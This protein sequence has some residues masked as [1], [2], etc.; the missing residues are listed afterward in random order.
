MALTRLA[1]LLVLRSAASSLSAAQLPR[2]FGRKEGSVAVLRDD[3]AAARDDAAA[4]PVSQPVPLAL[5]Q[6]HLYAFQAGGYKHNRIGAASPVLPPGCAAARNEG[7]VLHMRYSNGMC[8]QMIM[9][10]NVRVLAEQIGWG[11]T[12]DAAAPSADRAQVDWARR[13]PAAPQRIDVPGGGGGRARCAAGAGNTSSSGRGGAARVGLLWDEP[14][15]LPPPRS[16]GARGDGDG[17]GDG[18]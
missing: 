11:L 13:F 5:L 18:T 2:P 12:V 3:A 16:A 15:P 9:Y 1:S 4:R 10:A 7:G 6:Q 14:C 17:D 8:N